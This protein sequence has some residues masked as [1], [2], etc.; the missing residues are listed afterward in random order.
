MSASISLSERGLRAL[1]AVVQD[2]R[3]DAPG[4]GLPWATLDRLSELVRCDEVLLCEMDLGRERTPLEQSVESGERLLSVD[5]EDDDDGSRLFWKLYRDFLPCHDSARPADLRVIRWSDVYTEK[6]LYSA[7]LYVE[8]YRDCGARQRCMMVEF[9]AQPGHTRRLLFWRRSGR[10]F[11]YRDQLILELL[12]PHLYEI[13]RDAELRRR[14][15]PQLTRRERE[16][17]ELAAQGH[18]NADIARLLFISLSTVRKHMEHIFDRTGV[19]TRSAAIALMMPMLTMH[20]RRPPSD[21]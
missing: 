6:E 3:R 20:D 15:I 11:T 4:P 9:P 13:Y 16:V 19:R 7:P 18:S 5:S 14:G 21:R 2:G 17:L 12:W 1:L 10:D 8:L